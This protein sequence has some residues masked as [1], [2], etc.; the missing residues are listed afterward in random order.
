MKK[1]LI[2]ATLV[3]VLGALLVSSAAGVWVFHQRE[4]AAARQNLEELLI[5]MDAQSAITDPEGIIEQF[6]QAAPEKRLTIIDVDGTV[7]ADTE[8][9]PAAMENHADR[10]EV[11]Q[12]ALTGWGEALRPSESVGVTMLYEAKRFADGM[13]GRASM[14]VS[15]I[16]SLVLNSA[17]GFLAAAL[18]ALVVALLMASR[19]ARMVLR[20]LNVVGDALQGV[21]DGNQDREA[22]TRYEGDDEVR[23]LLRYIDKLVE[24]LGDHINQ[25]RAERDKVSLILECMDEGLILLDEAGSVLALNRAAK[26]LFGVGEDSDGSSVLLLTRSRAL[27][28]ALQTVRADKTPVVLDIEDLAF[29]ERSLRMFLSPVSGRQYEGESVGC[30]I[31]ISDVTDLKR[32]EG[33][34]SE[35]TANVSH[36]LKTPLTSIKGFTDMLSTGM[37]KDPED[38]KRFFSMIGVEVDRLIELINDILKLSELESVAIEQCEERADVLEAAKAAETLLSQAAASAGITLSVAGMP[39]EAA[40]PA[41][42]LK[43]LMLNLMENGVKYNEPGGRVDV[44]V[45]ADERF[46]TATVSD[47]GIGIPEEA[48]QRIFE[49]FYRVD[50]GR[51]RKNGGTGLGLAIV[52]HILQLY[53]GSVSVES[54]PGRGSA[55]TVKLPRGKSEF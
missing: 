16:D 1:R 47:T 37:V 7:L 28:Q 36:E 34:R 53:G 12:A 26:R 35:F 25:I 15:S 2:G 43:E 50:K 40:I 29:G 13:V 24:R 11:R 42:R 17:G 14:N 46:V 44:R 19:M 38:Q 51:A 22:L 30:S 18:V 20:P 32:A 54:E 55:F 49:R 21:L 41:G 45:S 33:I 4:M 8:A 9:D 52:K 3:T 10:S 48:R 31:L 27:R 23:P 39:A 6:V 5:L